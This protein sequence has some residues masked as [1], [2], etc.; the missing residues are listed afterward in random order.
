MSASISSPAPLHPSASIYTT[1]TLHIY[2]FLVLAFSNTYLWH[3]PTKSILLPFY[4][5]NA[6]PKHLDIGV[7]TGYYASALISSLNPPRPQ[8]PPSPTNP[9]TD[10]EIKELVLL[11]LN[12]S[13][14]AQAERRIAAP[15]LVRCVVGD[16][17]AP[18]PLRSP[19]AS[20]EHE[21]EKFDSISLFYLLH[22]LPGPCSSKCA[23]FANVAPHLKDDGAVFGATILGV[24]A[25]VRHNWL[26][27]RV[28]EGYN[29]RGI[30]GNRDDNAEEFVAALGKEF[31]N[32]ES[33]VVGAVLL[34]KA[35]GVK[36]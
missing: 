1:L 17:F 12:P 35:W 16:V 20:G 32:V 21:P 7:G 31:A 23:V 2:D 34:F 28:M 30:F 27:R 29:R 22:C 26:G 36:R 3:C 9:Q 6:G 15:E 25:G 14:L 18:L 8:D 19:A 24:G 10:R 11:D 5:T 4:I 33:K 13:C